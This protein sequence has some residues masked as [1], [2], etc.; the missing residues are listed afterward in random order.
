MI[1][2]L[3]AIILFFLSLLLGS[4]DV[5]DRS[6]ISSVSFS[7]RQLL[8]PAELFISWPMPLIIIIAII[9]PIDNSHAFLWSSLPVWLSC[10]EI[11]QTGYWIKITICS[12]SLLGTYL[13]SIEPFSL[14]L[15]HSRW[16]LGP[17]L[18]SSAEYRDCSAPISLCHIFASNDILGQVSTIA[19]AVVVILFLVTEISARLV[20]RSVCVE[21]DALTIRLIRLN[22]QMLI[23]DLPTLPHQLDLI[24]KEQEYHRWDCSNH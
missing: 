20:L 9:I 14:L 11:T 3:I 22:E 1:W 10:G 17:F 16:C 2:R 13:S 12:S 7:P 23:E 18:R 4:T 19:R 6:Q 21:D 5:W 15:M 8:F 24:D